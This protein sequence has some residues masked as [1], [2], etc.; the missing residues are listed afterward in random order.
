M[1]KKT[2]LAFLA[3][4]GGLLAL[5]AA[6]AHADTRVH[7]HVGV[8]GYVYTPPAPVYGQPGYVYA[9]PGYV[10][11]RPGHVQYHR[12]R[13]SFRGRD[14]DRD[15]IPDRFDRDRDNDGVPNRWDRRPDNPRRY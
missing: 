9:Q 5:S 7:L 10:R 2:A 8:P 15:G 13:N 14:G 12:H 3:A 11:A 1:G 4:A 6:P